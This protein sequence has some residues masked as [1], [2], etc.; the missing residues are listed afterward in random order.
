MIE[1]LRYFENKDA[2]SFGYK[3]F[4]ETPQDQYPTFSICLK[5]EGSDLYLYFDTMLSNLT[6]RMRTTHSDYHDILRGAIFYDDGVKKA[7]KQI[8]DL[9]K[10]LASQKKPSLGTLEGPQNTTRNQ[11]R[12]GA[13]ISYKK[14]NSKKE[15]GKARKTRK[16]INYNKEIADG[17]KSRHTRKRIAILTSINRFYV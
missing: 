2:S 16:I 5:S 6:G 1:S 10:D 13:I 12:R 9:E 14:P 3:Q 15:R 4:G 8:E 7:L 17:S 11:Q